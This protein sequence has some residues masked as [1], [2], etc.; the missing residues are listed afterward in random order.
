[1]QGLLVLYVK[2]VIIYIDQ[3]T[4]RGG[5]TVKYRI[6]YTNHQGVNCACIIEAVNGGQ[7]IEEFNCLMAGTGIIY[8][9]I[10]E[11]TK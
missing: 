4:R 6:G 2:D 1:M 7:A 5:G 9:Y 3:I 10:E 8:N 11:A